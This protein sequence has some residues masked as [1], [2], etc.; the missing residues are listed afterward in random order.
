M[1]ILL[2]I[3]AAA[4]L[5]V[6]CG[7]IEEEQTTTDSGVGVTTTAAPIPTGSAVTHW[8]GTKQLGT[9][10]DDFAIDITSDSS[11]NIYVTGY[12]GGSLDGN[13]SSGDNDSFVAKYDSGGIKQWTRQLG[14]SEEDIAIGITSD[15]SNNI[16]VTGYTGGSLD[17]NASSG[18]ND[19]FVAKYD[20]GGIKQWT[21]QI[22]T[23]NN[24]QAYDITSDPSGNIYVTGNTGGNLDGNASAGNDDILSG[25][26][27]RG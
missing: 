24:D 27:D 21:R 11:G 17:G 8:S 2:A 13:A 10:G 6:G 5:V 25:K 16:Y 12:T 22:G 9:S 14:T 20:S 19:S 23:S 1:K 4:S 15:P 18:D 3:I 7:V 26:Y